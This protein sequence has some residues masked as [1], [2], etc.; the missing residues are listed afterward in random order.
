[1]KYRY[2]DCLN[3]GGFW[4]FFSRQG[5]YICLHLMSTWCLWKSEQG[6][7]SLDQLAINKWS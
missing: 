6:F 3:S 2:E 5:F 4:F 1:M 7:A